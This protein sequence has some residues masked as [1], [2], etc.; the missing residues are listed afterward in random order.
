MVRRFSSKRMVTTNQIIASRFIARGTL[1]EVSPV[2]FFSQD[3]YEA[4]GEL[5]LPLMTL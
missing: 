3:E 1:V 5:D 2:L 4:H